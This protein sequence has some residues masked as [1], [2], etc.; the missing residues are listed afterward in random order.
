MFVAS[1]AFSDLKDRSVPLE[2]VMRRPFICHRRGTLTFEFLSGI[3][4]E[5]GLDFEPAMEP[6][7]SDLVLDL[8]SHGF[9]IG[10]V[11][12]QAAEQALRRGD[13]FALNIAEDIPPRSI[14]LL[15][16]EGHT[17]SLAARRLRDML[18]EDA[19]LP[20]PRPDA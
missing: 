5:H 9:G 11:P 17:L 18:T 15:E 20:A 3:C 12:E 6:E 1:E 8:V 10:F 16:Y 7:T 14:S 19:S 13:V 2:E 4:K